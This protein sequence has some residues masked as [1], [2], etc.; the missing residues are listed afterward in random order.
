MSR[1][2]A[3]LY[4]LYLR[5]VI[6]MMLSTTAMLA[7]ARPLPCPAEAPTGSQPSVSVWPDRCDLPIQRAL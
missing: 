4:D 1:R 6:A 5:R 7:A 3:R 2:D